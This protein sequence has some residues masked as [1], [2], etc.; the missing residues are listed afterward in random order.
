[1]DCKELIDKLENIEQL[2]KKEKSGNELIRIQNNLLSDFLKYGDEIVEPLS[3][4]LENKSPIIRNTAIHI[5][6]ASNNEK[7]IPYLINFLR[8]NKDGED[9]FCDDVS[10]VLLGY[11]EKAVDQII[12]SVKRDF[13][14]KIY[15]YWLV[16]AL[17]IESDRVYK[18]IKEILI[19]FSSNYQKYE[20]WFKIDDFIWKLV[21]Q[22]RK[23]S[24]QLAENLLKLNLT[25]DEKM[26]IRDACKAINNYED[27]EKE[28]NRRKLKKE[29]QVFKFM[30]HGLLSSKLNEI[31]QDGQ[32]PIINDNNRKEFMNILFSIESGI[33][34]Y[35]KKNPSIKDADVIKTLKNLR[36][37]IWSDYDGDNEFEKIILYNLK[38]EVFNDLELGYTKGEIS[39]CISYILNSVKKHKEYGDESYLEFIKKQFE[40]IETHG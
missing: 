21:V 32:R 39:A 15:N 20:N 2:L 26:E 13:E 36:D 5:I 9:E 17:S 30:L 18:F 3:K 10:R 29:E 27:Y 11:G 8:K 7:F 4:E 16:D 33:M 6:A 22:Q 34:K 14:N 24:V 40:K 28:K 38:S 19:D 23:D 25:R 1:M 12:M 35:Y 31:V 37:K